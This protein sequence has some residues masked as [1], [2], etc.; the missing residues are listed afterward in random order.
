MYLFYADE[1]GT[2]DPAVSGQRADGSRFGKDHLYV[3]AAAS[4]YEQRWHR[5]DKAIN[6]KKRELID[7]LDRSSAATPKLHL[8][9]CEV[10][11]TWLRIPKQR[12]A[13]SPF[14]HALTDADR[15]ALA[16]LFH[17]Q[18]GRHHMQVFAVVV[19]KRYLHDYFDAEKLHRKA[20]ELL[21]EPIERFLAEEH[22]KH[23]GVMIA[24]DV[25][26]R[27]NRRLAE[28]HQFLQ[29]A[30]TSNGLRLRRLIELPLFVPS[31]LSNGIQLADLIAY[32]VFRCFSRENPAYPFFVRCLPHLWSSRRS[33][34]D[35]LD[36]LRVFPPESPLTALLPRIAQQKKQ[37]SDEG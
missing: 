31:E 19:D 1:S 10:K 9:D 25:G 13:G 3:L 23:H 14:L 8:L 24:D 11:S 22:D 33:G 27:Q 18:L 15:T 34:R 12:K 35:Q 5:F 30:G 29:V 7:V 4:L 16:D 26:K 32:N 2:L 37:A 28:K 36:S 20:W 21:L 17:D 6:A